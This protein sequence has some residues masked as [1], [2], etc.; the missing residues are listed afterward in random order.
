MEIFHHHS[1]GTFSL[2]SVNEIEDLH[3]YAE[4]V[5]RNKGPELSGQLK[6]QVLRELV[7]LRSKDHKVPWDLSKPVVYQPGLSTACLAFDPYHLGFSRLR[8]LGAG[9]K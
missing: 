6:G 5:S 7:R 4:A 2:G 3:S 1:N 8:Q 9:K